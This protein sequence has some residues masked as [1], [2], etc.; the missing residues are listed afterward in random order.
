MESVGANECVN[1]R[2]SES[3]NNRKKGWNDMKDA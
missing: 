2:A 1:E 3:E